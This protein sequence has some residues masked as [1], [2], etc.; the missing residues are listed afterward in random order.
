[1]SKSK[2]LSKVEL[3][4][5]INEIL[6]KS[7]DIR[8]EKLKEKYFKEIEVIEKEFDLLKEKYNELEKEF[9]IKKNELLNL[10]EGKDISVGLSNL[11]DL[12]DYKDKRYSYNNRKGFYLKDNLNVN[13]RNEIY[14]ELVING[15]NEDVN[16]KEVMENY[17]NE[18]V[19]S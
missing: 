9:D 7:K 8:S 14:N 1:M 11:Y 13:L 16:I 19:N 12:R 4:V 15:I 10:C 3:E 6:K 17:I 2:K 5:V 18:V